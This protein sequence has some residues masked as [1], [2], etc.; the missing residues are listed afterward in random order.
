LVAAIIKA[1][2][3]QSLPRIASSTSFIKS[4]G[5]RIVLF[6]VAGM[7]GIL[8]L[9]IC[10]HLVCVLANSLSANGTKICIANAMHIWYNV[11]R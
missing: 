7:V 2:N 6:V 10:Y 11:V 5:N 9:P 4:F 8:N 1:E 3:V